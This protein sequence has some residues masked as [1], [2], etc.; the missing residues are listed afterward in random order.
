MKKLFIISLIVTML[1][2][3]PNYYSGTK[4]FAEENFAT[5]SNAFILIDTNT[6]NVLISK[7]E[8]EKMPIASIVKL[9]TLELLFD[10]IDLNNVS[11]DDE[12]SVSEY[13][14][15]MGGSQLFL[16]PNTT[17]KLKD[18]LKSVVVSSANDSAVVIAEYLAGSE[19]AFVAKMNEKSQELG[20]K[21]TLFVDCTGLDETGYSTAKDVSTL[22]R[23]V[24][25]NPIY[26]S[27]STIW[28]EMYT[29]PSGRETEIANTNK[30]IRT[31]NGC[32]AGKTGTT[33]KAGYCL[34]NLVER[35]N[36][37]LIAVVLGSKTSKLR[38]QDNAELIN[39]GFGNYK[40]Y[41]IINTNDVIK[42]IQMFK[43]KPDT[44]ALYAKSNFGLT[45]N[46]S[47]VIDEDN[48]ELKIVISE[49]NLP[50][51]SGS[52]MGII[53]IYYNNELVGKVD[54][55]TRTDINEKSIKDLFIS[56]LTNW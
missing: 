6:S 49:I 15:S 9:M 27:F 45:I 28:L 54:L 16:D 32:K 24:L 43:A 53:E 50:V 23:N 10:E 26:Q 1:L 11:L 46:R 36:M 5:D 40:Y 41:E 29:H 17:H 55:E 31:L 42:E 38:F 52:V 48:L 47:Q 2:L 37:S 8:N 22:S 56:V 35:N 44:V 13:A 12:L 14:S 33:E 18:L 30:L 25:T 20:M 34:T 7:N 39:Y 4:A 19:K 51:S 21:D 3:I